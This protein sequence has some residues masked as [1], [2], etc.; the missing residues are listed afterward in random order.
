MPPWKAALWWHSPCSPE[1]GALMQWL[2][3]CKQKC[4]PKE[5]YLRPL[6]SSGKK[7]RFSNSFVFCWWVLQ[8]NL[9]LIPSIRWE[10]LGC[11]LVTWIS[12]L[13]G[14]HKTDIWRGTENLF[15]GRIISCLLY[16]WIRT[17]RG[18]GA[19]QGSQALFDTRTHEWNASY[20]YM[21]THTCTYACIFTRI[22]RLFC[23]SRQQKVIFVAEE[24][25]EANGR[26]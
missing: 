2:A 3:F 26:P 12:P 7:K 13:L 15:L 21:H 24:D 23:Q 14:P 11:L 25:K 16:T 20:T 4:C 1:S 19:L 22:S 17:A 18:F 9:K 10:K 6:K 5:R 8:G